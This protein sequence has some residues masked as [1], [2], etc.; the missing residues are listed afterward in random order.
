MINMRIMI[1]IVVMLSSFGVYD[2]IIVRK[3]T[4]AKEAPQTEKS[5]IELEREQLAERAKK[6]EGNSTYDVPPTRIEM[7]SNEDAIA[8]SSITLWSTPDPRDSGSVSSLELMIKRA[9]ENSE[10]PFSA[11][12]IELTDDPLDSDYKQRLEAV[13][14]SFCTIDRLGSPTERYHLSSLW[15]LPSKT[16]VYISPNT[17]ISG[18]IT[19]LLS[20]H[21]PQ[22]A[23]IGTTLNY[24]EDTSS[25]E[26]EFN[27]AGVFVLHPREGC[28]S[29]IMKAIDRKQ[30]HSEGEGFNAALNSMWKYVRWHEIGFHYAANTA[31]YR[32]EPLFWRSKQNDIRIIHYTKDL[33]WASTVISEPEA[34]WKAELNSSVFVSSMYHKLW[35]N[36]GSSFGLETAVPLQYAPEP[37]PDPM[38]SSKH[39]EKAL[40]IATQDP[41]TLRI[42]T[43]DRRSTRIQRKI[44]EIYS[45]RFPDDAPVDK[46]WTIAIGIPSVDTVKG[47]KLRRIQRGTSFAYDTVWNYKK[48]DDARVV[49]KY[50]LARHPDNNYE[51]SQAVVD[52]A[53]ETKDIIFFDIKE[54]RPPEPGELLYERKPVTVLVGMSRKLY[55]WFCYAVDRFKT[56]YVIKGDDDVYIRVNRLV[57]ELSSYRFPKVYFGRGLFYS[58]IRFAF[59]SDGPLIALSYDLVDWIRDSKIAESKTDFV[60]EDILPLIWMWGAN[61]QANNISDCRVGQLSRSTRWDREMISVHGLKGKYGMRLFEKFRERYPDSHIPPT[62]VQTAI[63]LEN[64]EYIQFNERRKCHIGDVWRVLGSVGEKPGNFTGF[65]FD[66]DDDLTED[67][68]LFK[69][70]A[71]SSFGDDSLS[72]SSSHGNDSQHSGSSNGN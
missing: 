60:Y 20:I 16:A 48:R 31:L 52:E 25:W 46:E 37:T 30:T 40:Q 12:L 51:P 36:M 57:S 44:M 1:Y 10:V 39:G 7:C 2:K 54:G 13:G 3:P 72:G 27:T 66:D 32:S 14:W 42:H 63:R 69:D 64:G 23:C 65:D 70:E 24:N 6:K 41:E 58:K 26:A 59:R 29:D 53:K 8:T 55:A 19:Q 56:D 4:I 35:G 38:P 33:P 22:P 34:W 21:M 68:S 50:L 62:K 47:Q 67:N 61:I 15:K 71:S 18:K 45:D 11:F 17:Y 43:S 28:Y 49:L 9:R 5:F